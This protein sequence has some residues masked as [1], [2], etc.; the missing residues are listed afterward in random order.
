MKTTQIIGAKVMAIALLCAAACTSTKIVSTWRSPDAKQIAFKRVLVYAPLSDAS[1]R[2]N[3]EDTLAQYITGNNVGR[4]V[5]VPSYTVINESELTDKDV[6]RRRVR[7]GGFDGV[8]V[9]RVVAVTREAYWVPG[10]YWGPYYAGPIYDPS[11]VQIDT[12]VRLETDVYEASDEKLVWASA[13]QTT[14]PS[15]VSKMTKEVAS[16]NAKEMRKQGLIP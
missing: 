10:T 4:T 7:E 9:F 16:A 2:R 13:S 8:V 14:N 3:T 1:Q 15:S 5:A 6:L 11:Y 12:I